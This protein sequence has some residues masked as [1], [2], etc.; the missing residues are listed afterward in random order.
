MTN[1][2]SQKNEQFTTQSR[3]STFLG[4]SPTPPINESSFSATDEAASKLS[5]SSLSEDIYE[6][7]EVDTPS[8]SN[9][10]Y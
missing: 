8:I 5:K 10:T 4:D 1:V 2:M 9:K 7:Y 3:K 6:N